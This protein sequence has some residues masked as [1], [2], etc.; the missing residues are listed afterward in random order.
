M[1]NSI[2]NIVSKIDAV[3]NKM[4][5]MDRAKVKR[6]ENMNKILNTISESDDLDEKAKRHHMEKMVREELQRW[7]SDSSL[8]T[9]AS[10]NG[11]PSP[12]KNK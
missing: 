10:G 5:A 6:R 1:E 12:K 8:R 11:N 9:P 7:D 4:A 2:G 3:L